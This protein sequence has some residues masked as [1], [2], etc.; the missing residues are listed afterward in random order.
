MSQDNNTVAPEPILLTYQFDSES[1][2]IQYFK[3]SLNHFD[4][5]L[6]QPEGTVSI[7]DDILLS[8]DEYLSLDTNLSGLDLYRKDTTVLNFQVGKG[9]TRLIHD[10]ML[11]YLANPDMYVIFYV[12]PLKRLLDQNKSEIEKL[13]LKEGK[14]VSIW[15]CTSKPKPPERYHI[16]DNGLSANIYLMTPEFLM[17][18]GGR[19]YQ[20]QSQARTD[21]K[22]ALLNHIKKQDK[23]IVLFLDE[24]H[25]K[26]SMYSTTRF[27]HLYA[28]TP[29]L[30]SKIFVASATF[31]RESV[32]VVKAVSMLTKRRVTVFQGDRVKASKQADLHLHICTENYKHN[33][34]GSLESELNRVL[35][36]SVKDR[37][38]VH[39]LT[40]HKEMA[41]SLKNTTGKLSNV[42]SAMNP[43]LMTGDDKR[44]F[45]E[46]RNSIGTTFTTGI[47]ITEAASTLVVILPGTIHPRQSGTNVDITTYG[48]FNS[49]YIALIQ[50]VARLRNGGE[51]HVFMR[52]FDNY[53]LSEQQ[54][55]NSRAEY[56][57]GQSHKPHSVQAEPEQ[58][59][60]TR[61]KKVHNDEI[62]TY[63]K[64]ERGIKG[65]ND[66]T[67][68]AHKEYF[69]TPPKLYDF[70]LSDYANYRMANSYIEGKLLSP[71][72]L[73]LAL[74][75][76]FTNCTLKTATI[77]P[78][79]SDST[80]KKQRLQNMFEQSLKEAGLEECL[81]R[82]PTK[83]LLLISVLLINSKEALPPLLEPFQEFSNAMN[84]CRDELK[85]GA[86]KNNN[87]SYIP[88]VVHPQ[89]TDFSWQA[90]I[91]AIEV[92]RQHEFTQNG[93]IALPMQHTTSPVPTEKIAESLL[94]KEFADGAMIMTGREFIRGRKYR[95]LYATMS[96]TD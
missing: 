39:I 28:I 32:E 73:W 76:Q 7:K 30:V 8:P 95:K 48:I 50:S 81:S 19:A 94:I 20:P 41:K 35:Q 1:P 68:V 65:S 54:R 89:L 60:F 47:N 17:G 5:S 53:I 96:S 46:S 4:G 23:T 49:G 74:N 82:T 6:W 12:A 31:T 59:L 52:S 14:Q 70:I 22:K 21:F 87:G 62:K 29:E 25:E 64:F 72:L 13:S 58:K 37:G 38:R 34:L 57:I 51:V 80:T 56:L 79:K 10:C 42:M 91:K 9:K 44:N 63:E 85:S 45:D 83:R 86:I 33:S 16:P 92:I 3:L 15:D 78:Y 71:L 69:G 66:S 90:L 61:F 93:L 2:P 77:E 26:V 11:R 84:T 27:A 36:D 40:A 75:N 67:Y 24:A 43:Q 55:V 88:E 18:S